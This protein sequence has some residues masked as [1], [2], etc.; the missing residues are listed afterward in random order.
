MLVDFD[1]RPDDYTGIVE[2]KALQRVDRSDLI[3]AT[4]ADPVFIG[5]IPTQRSRA[6][7]INI[8]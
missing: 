8:E 5:A 1:I 7:N 3:R 2:V 4:F 6:G